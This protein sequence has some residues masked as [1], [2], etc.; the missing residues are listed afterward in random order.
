M[1]DQLALVTLGDGKAGSLA[2]AD[3]SGLTFERGLQGGF[4][5][6]G[7]GSN[8]G[9]DGFA[10]IEFGAGI[11]GFKFFKFWAVRGSHKKKIEFLLTV[12]V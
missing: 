7:K 8:S 10:V 11:F 1:V 9:R 6:I 3:A 12:G 4:E 5:E 2:S